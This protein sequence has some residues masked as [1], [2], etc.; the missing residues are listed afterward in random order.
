MLLRSRLPFL[1][2]PSHLDI[3]RRVLVGLA[4]FRAL[5]DALPLRAFPL[6]VCWIVGERRILIRQGRITG[7]AFHEPV[8]CHLEILTRFR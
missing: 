1:F 6:G 8:L 7:L 2:G 4:A 3:G 5:D